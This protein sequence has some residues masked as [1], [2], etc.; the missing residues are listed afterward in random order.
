MTLELVLGTATLPCWPRLC[1]LPLDGQVME[2]A[3]LSGLSPWTP[4]PLCHGSLAFAWMTPSDTCFTG[5]FAAYP[6]QSQR[7]R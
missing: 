7:L 6:H 1:L 3:G 2:D 4:G 5:T